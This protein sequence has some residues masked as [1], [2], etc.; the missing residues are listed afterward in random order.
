MRMEMLKLVFG[1]VI[2]QH[3]WKVQADFFSELGP[4]EGHSYMCLKYWV[5]V[6]V[7]FFS[8]LLHGV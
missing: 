6:V 8:S 7:L 4:R 2:S 1:S 3:G 5:V